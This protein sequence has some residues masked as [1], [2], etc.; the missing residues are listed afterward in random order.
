MI[1]IPAIDIRNGKVV[2]LVQGDYARSTEYPDSPLEV[3]RKWD[4]C[5]VKM[6]HVVDLDGALIGEPRN[7]AIVSDIAKKVKAR[8]ELGGGIRSEEVVSRILDMG[9]E[10]VVV[11]T[12]ALNDVF[13]KNLESR[14]R[15]RVVAAIDARG[16][17]VHTKGWRA[18]SKIKAVEFAKTLE[19]LGVKTINYTDISKDG[20]M[21][22]L[23]LLSIEEF[24]MGRSASVV[25]GGGISSL[26]D[27]KALK[28]MERYKLAGIIIGKA[29]YENKLDLVE[30]IKIAEAA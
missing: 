7:L 21:E 27:I 11:G 9:V 16:G 10:K 3:A 25:V 13:M 14:F 30:A 17:I 8:I 4:S 12:M 26:D 20:L 6:I 2:R 28:K 19:G 22:G 29:L 23:N 24:L 18:K 15:E 1:V 5:G